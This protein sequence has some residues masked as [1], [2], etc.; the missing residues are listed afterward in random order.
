[1]KF[2]KT[3]L[4]LFLIS[5]AVFI[6]CKPK[7]SDLQAKVEKNL[8]GSPETSG[9]TVDV[10]DGVATLSGEVK[11]H[12]AVEKAAAS[13]QDVNGIKSVV[14]NVTMQA[15][16]VEAPPVEVNSDA[17]MMQGVKDAT[18]D[19]PTVTANVNDGVITLTGSVKRSNLQ[20]L[21]MSLNTLKPKKID[22][23]LTIK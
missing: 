5:S 9:V 18:K 2:F 23:Q 20:T 19:F 11:V 10:K 4:I 13:A 8:Q 22:N 14:N 15:P 7:D 1:M 6:G 17:T 16:V 3:Y 12:N 21:M